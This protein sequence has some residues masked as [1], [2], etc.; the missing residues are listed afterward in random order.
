MRKGAKIRSQRKI[1][2]LTLWAKPSR[3]HFLRSATTSAAA[4]GLLSTAEGAYRRGRHKARTFF[5]DFSHEAHEGATYEFVLG[6]TKYRLEAVNP[7]H[8]AVLAGRRRNKFLALLPDSAITHVVEQAM[9]ST[10]SLQAA[11]VIKDANAATGEWS[12]SAMYAIP[13]LSGYAHAFDLASRKVSA[14]QPI[15]MSAKRHLYGQPAAETLQDLLDEQ[16]HLGPVDWATA[17]AN[18]HPEALSAEGKSAA[19]IQTN[20]IQTD[21]GDLINVVGDLRTAGPAMP[22]QAMT[23]S[24]STGWATLVPY[25]DQNGAPIKSTKGN[26]TGLILYD[27]KWNPGIQ[28]HLAQFMASAIGSVKNDTTLG[29]DVTHRAGTASS[30]NDLLGQIWFR[31]DGAAFET[32]AEAARSETSNINFA[33]KNFTPQQS[34]YSVTI[35][36]SSEANVTLAFTNWYS[37]WLG[38]YLQFSKA[39]NVL[40]QQPSITINPPVDLPNPTDTIY[41]GYIKPEL[42]VLGIPVESSTVNISFDFPQ[43]ASSA[44]ILASGLGDGS[45]H[46]QQTE[47]LGIALTTIFNLSL[48]MV[49]LFFGL[50]LELDLFVKVVVVPFITAVVKF[51]ASEIA[52]KADPQTFFTTFWKTL[53]SNP[54]PEIT[55]FVEQVTSFITTGELGNAFEDTVPILGPIL[56]AL[57]ALVAVA[58]VAETACEVVL[59]PWTYVDQLTATHDVSL[60][61]QPDPA[62]HGQ[63]GPVFPAA[64]A[65]YKVTAVVNGGTPRIQVL[66]V[67]GQPGASL[68]ATF[69]NLPYGGTIVLTVAFYASDGATTAQGTLV[70][71]GTTGKIPN[72]GASSAAGLS[73]SL[74]ITELKLPINPQTVYLHKQKTTIGSNGDHVWACAN[75]PAAPS[76]ENCSNKPGQL[77]EFRGISVNYATGDI[78]YDWNSYT[79]VT[80]APGGS[81]L[82]DQMASIPSANGDQQSGYAK[83]PCAIDSGSHLIYSPTG[84]PHANFYLDSSNGHNLLRQVN[85][86]PPGFSNPK[87]NQAWGKLNL[88]CNDL[89][90]HPSGAAVSINSA[91]GKLETIKLPMSPMSDVDA[92]TSLL[93][94]LHAGSGSRPGLFGNPVATALTSE[95]VVLVLEQGN[96]RIHA[97]DIGA[98]PHPLFASQSSK[99]FLNLTE[100]AGA[101]YLDLAV[102]F[103]GFI[104]VLSTLS[105]IYYLDIYHF[106]QSGT[107][108]VSRT[109]G[110]NAAKVT[111]DYWR[112]VYSLN[113]EVLMQNGSIPNGVTEPSIS[114]WLPIASPCG[115]ETGPRR[116]QA[117]ETPRRL[118]RR[119]LFWRPGSVVG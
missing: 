44:A 81:G 48:P 82:L 26:N 107:T 71:H 113:Y 24:N 29:S 32:Q 97:V 102:E 49:L 3:R 23:V 28:P 72:A 95:G 111:V 35:A 96:N 58:N 57:G 84:D 73:A 75:A 11:Y 65:Y 99:Y 63:N 18:Y 108:P 43:N 101:T 31:H 27:A 116:L 53:V 51:I 22:Q 19:N 79:S 4:L 52:T 64:A 56:Q 17:L 40:P 59:S 114:Q 112:N 110:F 30:N 94:T 93:A 12:M 66:T 14:G 117:F 68:S 88:P 91:T 42:T 37:R 85:L 15:A 92:S 6:G 13:P 103:T 109:V 119:Q 54:S 21:V 33:L 62:H 83:L 34:G 87:S 20:H 74:A 25:T 36:S 70:G 118:L 16:E 38:L 86:S 89:L 1:E 76:G 46:F 61:I 7:S 8:P 104:Y 105:G 2:R 39:G 90:L 9:A 5:F 78:G 100:T 106:Q 115:A 69:S 98:N 77:C 10:D 50:G 41:I 67:P 60:T 47:G 55:A 45:H 80:C